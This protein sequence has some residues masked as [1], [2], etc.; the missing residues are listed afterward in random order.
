MYKQHCGVWGNRSR[1]AQTKI[2]RRRTCIIKIDS[3]IA[4]REILCGM[5]AGSTAIPIRNTESWKSISRFHCP[6]YWL[7]Q[8]WRSGYL[9]EGFCKRR[10]LTLQRIL[11]SH[12]NTLH[13]AS[14]LRSNTGQHDLSRGLE[15]SDYILPPGHYHLADPSEEFKLAYRCWQYSLIEDTLYRK[16]IV[17][18]LLKCI[19]R[20]GEGR[21]LMAEVH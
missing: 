14:R 9:G 1:P 15:G 11:P 7:L 12:R 2:P 19:I 5:W 3:K 20:P 8:K 21:E 10:P 18:P 4:N 6:T 17:Q 16:G 13:R